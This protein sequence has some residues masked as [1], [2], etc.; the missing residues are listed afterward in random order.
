MIETLPEFHIFHQVVV[1][2]TFF[3]KKML[4]LIAEA[5]IQ[6]WTMEISEHHSE[7]QTEKTYF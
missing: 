4:V 2:L 3:I 7:N 5:T 1:E 6:K